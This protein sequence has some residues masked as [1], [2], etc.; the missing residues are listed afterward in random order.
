MLN[1]SN[2]TACRDRASWKAA[3]LAE[4]HS[5]VDA[6]CSVIAMIEM[7]Q[8][9]IDAL[10]KV[11]SESARGASRTR[12]HLMELSDAIETVFAATS[13]YHLRTAGRVALK[14]KQMLAQAVASLNELPESVTD[15]QTPPRILAETT[16]EA[17]VHV[18]E[19]TGVLLRVMGHADEEVQTLQAAF[20]AI[21]VAQPR[22][23]L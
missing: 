10:R 17:L 1:Q 13:P 9:E 14:L 22:T 7:K 15:G 11:V 3:Q 19:T 5:L 8:N 16:E 6:I 23:G 18:R 21:S 12:P 4:L 20:L 2:P